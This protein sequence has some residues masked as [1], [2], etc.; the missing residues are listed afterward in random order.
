MTLGSIQQLIPQLNYSDTKRLSH[1]VKNKLSSDVVAESEDSV[2]E[3]P[4]CQSLDFIKHGTT[5]K[6]LQRYRCKQCEAT[7]TSLTNTPLY[8]MQKRDKWL[9]YAEM[10]WDGTPLRTIAAR[11]G[12]TLRTAFF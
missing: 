1:I 11:L 2:C 4:F 5:Y 12:N 3:C 8:R 7:F 9:D 10:M 6:G